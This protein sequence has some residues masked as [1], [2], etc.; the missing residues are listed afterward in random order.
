MTPRPVTPGYARALLDLGLLRA[1]S[2]EDVIDAAEALADAV[3]A[4]DEELATL[5]ALLAALRE[6]HLRAAV[7]R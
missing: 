4:Q 3:A 5:R 1:M 7:S 6:E 2:S